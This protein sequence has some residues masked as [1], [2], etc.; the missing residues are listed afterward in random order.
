PRDRF[1]RSLSPFAPRK[2]GLS[3]SERRQYPCRR[4]KTM[5]RQPKLRECLP[6]LWQILSRFR[7]PIRKQRGL[8]IG[9]L[10]L[11]LTGV[12]LR[13]LEPWPLKIVFDHVIGVRADG[14]VAHLA[15]LNALDPMT[16]LLLAALAFGVFIGFW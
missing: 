9:S 16:L 15:V 12:G 2:D 5:K 13:L 10:L 3:P 11:L 14:T 6:G 8:I 4:D 7:A 1:A